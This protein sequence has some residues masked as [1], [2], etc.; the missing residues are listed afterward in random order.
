MNK[1]LTASLI[2]TA[3][4]VAGS[5]ASAQMTEEA[6]RASLVPFYKSL[7]A[8]NAKDAPELIRQSTT[9]EWVT[10]RGNDLCNTRDEVMAAV[11]QRLKAIPDLKWDIKEVLVSGNRVIVR[12]EATGT[13]AGELMGAPTNGKSFKLMSLDVHTLEGGKIARTYHVEDWQG[14]FRQMAQKQALPSN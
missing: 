8:V 3:M 11:G 6:A 14:A 13:P 2:A 4:A 5:P 9:P 12:G 7:N 1:A 10:C